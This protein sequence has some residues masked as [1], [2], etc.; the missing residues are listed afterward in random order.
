MVCDCCWRWVKELQ[1]S[2]RTNFRIHLSAQPCKSPPE[3]VGVPWTDITLDNLTCPG[4]LVQVHV[5]LDDSA[6]PC[7]RLHFSSLIH[8]W[9]HLISV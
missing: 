4:K 1:S 8:D 6:F 2:N 7:F 9:L 5:A 3:L